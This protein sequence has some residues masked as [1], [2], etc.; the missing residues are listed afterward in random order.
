MSREVVT[1]VRHR[2]CFVVSLLA[3]LLACDGQI[4]SRVGG[5]PEEGVPGARL[6]A[7]PVTPAPAQL[8]LLSGAEYRA[9]VKDLLGVDASP[10][11][12][13]A[14]WSSGFDTGAG[15]QL[16]EALFD[17]LVQEA[18]ALSA[19]A[20]AQLPVAFP[21]LGAATLDDACVRTLIVQLGRRAHRHPLEPAQAEALFSAFQAAAQLTGSRREGVQ[22]VVARL[23]LSPQFLYRAEV[24]Q[25]TARGTRELDAFERASFLSYVLTGSMPDEALLADAEAGRLDDATARLHV[26]RLWQTPRARARMAALFRQWLKLGALDDMVARPQD[27]PKLASPAQGVA[28]RDGFDAFVTT[29]LFD[30]AGTL[31]ATFDEPAVMV[32]QHTA[33]LVGAKAEGDTLRRVEVPRAERRG[34]LTQPGLL[35]ALGASGDALRDRPVMRGFSIKTQLLCEPI[36]PPSGVN[37]AVAASTAASIPGFDELTT[38][39]QY[40]AMMEQGAACS[41]CHAQ[42]MPLGFAFG[43]YDALGRFRTTL[44]Q[45]AVDPSAR[46]VPV[47]G[48]V[49]DFTDGLELSDV[50]AGH[51]AVAACFTRHLAAFTLGLGTSEPV[52]TLAASLAH[53][54]AGAPLHVG[55][56]LEAL[57]LDPSWAER[58][59]PDS[60]PAGAGG[61]AGGGAAGGGAPGGGAAGGASGPTAARLLASGEELRPNERRQAFG[62][63]FTFVYQGDGNLVLYRAGR[64]L[65]SSGTAGQPAYLAAMQ[66]D[67]N[68]V[69]YARPA[70]PV[71]NTQT[72]GHAGAQLFV[73]STGRLVLRATDGRELVSATPA[74]ATP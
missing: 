49:R 29:V 55:E 16:Q 5:R 17:V 54:R 41:T 57:L 46:G 44:R 38:R 6:P 72:N 59:V 58:V 10:S 27:F 34:L 69:V 52:V 47:L 39:Q 22:H 14:D 48:Q 42:F 56:T 53:R 24:G 28:L 62:G 73:E 20:M 32:N 63:T 25:P 12:T 26:R 65:W 61:G 60:P 7:P 11:L 31:K 19:A 67:G 33:A 23:L 9:T 50:L 36:G 51:E 3:S 2:A 37:T 66:G 13:H 70:A 21:C 35:A 45:R 18:E 4:V 74:G 8:R 1:L 40:E 71:F 30:G 64:A 43:R 68:L 15:T